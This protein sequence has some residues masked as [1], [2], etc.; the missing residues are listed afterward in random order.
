MGL[1]EDIKLGLVFF[2]LVLDG[3]L[4]L[5]QVLTLLFEAASVAHLLDFLSTCYH[6]V[7]V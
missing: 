5:G 7:G 3:F 6:T 4:D 2:F 1:L